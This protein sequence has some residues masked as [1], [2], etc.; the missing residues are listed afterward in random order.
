MSTG[1]PVDVWWIPTLACALSR[2]LSGSR[3]TPSRPSS[4]SHGPPQENGPAPGARSLIRDEEWIVQNA[5][6]C[7]LGGWQLSCIGVSETIRNRHALSLTQL[8]AVT[9]TDPAKTDLI[10]DTSPIRPR[11]DSHASACWEI[12]MCPVTVNHDKFVAAAVEQGPGAHEPVRFGTV[13]RHRP[14]ALNEDALPRW[15]PD[16]FP[17]CGA[18]HG[19]AAVSR[20]Q[21]S[22]PQG[23]EA[24][25]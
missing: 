20:S 19:A 8:E 10:F 1:S 6:M 25:G 16:D 12:A 4:V 5:E 11:S 22:N 17:R 14:D 13:D 7:D 9:F 2:A 15:K 24:V 21:R 18:G 23:D 3:Q